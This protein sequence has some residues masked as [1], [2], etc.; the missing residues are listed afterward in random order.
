MRLPLSPEGDRP[1]RVMLMDIHTAAQEIMHGPPVKIDARNWATWLCPFHDD[2][3]K[4]GRRKQPNF[5]INLENGQWKYLRCWKSG[6]SLNSLR[7]EL[8][9]VDWRPVAVAR[10][11]PNYWG[12]TGAA[13]VQCCGSG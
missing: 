12:D 7:R 9:I 8:G 4:I 13:A 5:G 10:T 1:R 6:G 3:A 11:P 2:A